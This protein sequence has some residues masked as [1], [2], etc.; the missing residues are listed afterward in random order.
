MELANCLPEHFVRREGNECKIYQ[1]TIYNSE[2]TH[3]VPICVLWPIVG[4]K[5]GTLSPFLNPVRTSRS[6]LTRM[7]NED[8]HV[9][10][11]WEHLGMELEVT[12]PNG[13]ILYLPVITFIGDETHILPYNDCTYTIPRI[14]QA[15]VPRRGYDIVAKQY[16]TDPYYE[17]YPREAPVK[18]A[19]VSAVKDGIKYISFIPAH[20]KRI[21]V[22]NAISHNEPCPISYEDITDT[23][24]SV[25]SCGHVF[26]TAAIQ[27]WLSRKAAN[28]MCPVCKQ[29]C[30][31]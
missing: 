29:A 22:T 6:I 11:K 24:A 21:L 27:N 9:P 13:V 31:L 16:R 26:N 30:S 10:C 1:T 2:E 3:N 18:P 19:E 20:V 4:M 28:S 7:W 14:N 8:S 12:Q 5:V 17:V 15:A 25:T 23:T